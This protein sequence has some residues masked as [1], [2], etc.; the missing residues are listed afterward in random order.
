LQA[1]P[2]WVLATTTTATTKNIANNLVLSPC[3]YGFFVS[4]T[5]EMLGQE[6]YRATRLRGG[7][8]VYVE[9]QDSSSFI[10]G[11]YLSSFVNLSV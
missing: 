2:I 10:C 3:F 6:K 1:L 9:L 5:R 7:C 11:S 4:G 8:N